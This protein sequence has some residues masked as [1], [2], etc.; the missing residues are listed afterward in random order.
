MRTGN[1]HIG[2]L[3]VSGHVFIDEKA[4]FTIQVE[5]VG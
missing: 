5:H 3:K 1:I 4:I 2:A